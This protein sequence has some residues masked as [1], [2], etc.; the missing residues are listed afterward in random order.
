M[1]DAIAVTKA[2]GDNIKAAKATRADF[3]HALHMQQAQ[4]SGWTPKVVACSALDGT[5]L[6]ELRD[7]A[8]AFKNQLSASGHFAQN[9]RDQNTAWFRDHFHLL[10]SLDPKQYAYVREKEHAL[11]EL[12][13]TNNI[14]PRNAARQLLEA[15]HQAIKK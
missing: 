5:G 6:S 7:L 15:Y 10:L 12:I 14:S 9:R 2:D 4:R 11:K 13:R 3:Q 1:A 8:E